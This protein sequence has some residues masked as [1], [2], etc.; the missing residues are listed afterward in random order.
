M[1][2]KTMDRRQL[3]KAILM[4]GAGSAFALEQ[5]GGVPMFGTW[6]NGLLSRAG[7][8]TLDAYEMMGSAMRGGPAF[9]A[10]QQAIAQQEIG[11][12]IVDIKVVNHVST[13]LVFAFGGAAV[14]G[15]A[16]LST[17]KAALT[18][19]V[20]TVSDVAPF[21]ALKLNKW[22]ANMLNKGTADGLARTAANSRGLEATDIAD[23]DKDKVALQA[24]V[25][26]PQIPGQQNHSMKGLKVRKD[27]GDITLLA[28]QTGLIQSPL[29]ITCLMMGQGYDKAEG[30]L[31]E[32]AILDGSASERAVVSSRD[33]AAYV[34]QISQFV[35]ASY[36]NKASMEQSLYP[37]LDGLVVKEAPL[38]TELIRSRDNFK[39]RLASL[40]ACADL[41][42]TRLTV[43]AE[44]SNTQSSNG[45]ANQGASS[46]FVAQCKYVSQAMELSGVPLRNFSLFLNMVDLDGKDY[47]N[48]ANLLSAGQPGDVQAFSYTEGM[49]QLAMGLNVLAKQIAGGKKMIVYVH[50]EG[51]RDANNGDGQTSFAFVMGPRGAD[52]LESHLYYEEAKATAATNPGGNPH[53][54]EGLMSKDGT[55]M[56]AQADPGDVGL[57]VI[58]FLEGVTKVNAR[59]DLAAAD[60]RYIKLKRFGA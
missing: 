10:V 56:D 58:E 35:G 30:D 6:V 20:D 27:V 50:A 59:K 49:R 31:A 28:Q 26:L 11:W 57:G 53:K 24:F 43:D 36:V 12:T 25:G 51:G 18:P 9:L 2:R 41:E 14:K 15:S 4:G 33:I 37:M 54:F 16:K 34:R 29:G 52:G 46:A 22:F 21:A 47:E 8:N 39:A 40:Q 3:M 45:G 44:K 5:L 23:F 7:V 17:A 42:T 55:A 38:R 19:L 60:G 32:N 1:A 13:P 48:A